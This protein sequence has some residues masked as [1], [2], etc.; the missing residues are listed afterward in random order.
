MRDPKILLMLN[1]GLSAN[2]RSAAIRAAERFR[3]FEVKVDII[4]SGDAKL[5]PSRQAAALC[6]C[7]FG[8][9]KETLGS[10]EF[11]QAR[12]IFGREP[13]QFIPVGVTP[14]KLFFWDRE[15]GRQP[16]ERLGIYGAGAALSL[17][18]MRKLGQSGAYRGYSP[19]TLMEAVEIALARDIGRALIS[20]QRIMKGGDCA[21]ADCI[22]Q[23]AE[24]ILEFA[25]MAC[26]RTDFCGECR[27]DLKSAVNYTR[28]F[29][30]A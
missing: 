3:E 24:N 11:E 27:G 8:G 6:R 25:Q 5:P 4:G 10:Y 1:G 13:P 20:S 9:E 14:E 17:A 2:E 29:A 18:D 28:H 21:S 30:M 15:S 12:G 19:E 23:K 22:M 16:V 7:I 26:A